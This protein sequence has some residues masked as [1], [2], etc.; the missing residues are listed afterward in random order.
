[1]NSACERPHEGKIGRTGMSGAV[2]QSRYEP[3]K[4]Y[5][6][7][8]GIISSEPAPALSGASSAVDSNSAIVEPRNSYSRATWESSPHTAQRPSDKIVD[9]VNG[10]KGIPMS[11][12]SS[13][14]IRHSPVC[15]RRD[16][17]QHFGRLRDGAQAGDDLLRI[18]L[19]AWDQCPYGLIG[20]APNAGDGHG[21][22][23]QR[24]S[25]RARR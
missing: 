9:S 20:R 7:G 25:V 4:A 15:G 17:L 6:Q 12:K 16:H 21:Q 13:L 5:S 23:M 10:G 1:M 18:E 11:N 8:V 2:K 24:V 19:L 14:T 22:W 3:V